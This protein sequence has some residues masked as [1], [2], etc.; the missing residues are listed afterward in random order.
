MALQY[1]GYLFRYLLWGG[2][3]AI[4]F[5][6]FNYSIYYAPLPTYYLPGRVA[7]NPHFSEALFGN[8]ISPARGLFVFS[9]IFIF[10][11]LGL[12]SKARK[13]KFEI[14]DYF[15]IVIILLHW[16]VISNFAHWWGGWS[17]GPRFFSDMVPYFI[18]FMVPIM[19]NIAKS[20]GIRKIVVITIFCILIMFSLLVHYM[21]ANSRATQNWNVFPVNVDL[22]SSRVWDW[23]DLQFLKGIRD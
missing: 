9:P 17:F 20:R 11:F 23:S 13:Q 2:T 19:G 1:R 16:I 10:S 5:I 21:G 12:I 14:L 7:N 22:K 15:L 3:L 4:G 6:L 8:L 18:Y